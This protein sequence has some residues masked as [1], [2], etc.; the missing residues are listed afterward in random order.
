MGWHTNQL[1]LICSNHGKT[2]KN[3][4]WDFSISGP[5]STGTVRSA[6][7]PPQSRERLLNNQ[8]SPGRLLESGNQGLPASRN[9]SEDS[10]G[11]DARDWETSYEDVSLSD[12]LSYCTI[13]SM[14][15]FSTEICENNQ[16][17]L[18]MW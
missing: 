13:A 12:P 9:T 16:F 14:C 4:G 18:K 10:F 1:V 7:K 5:Q 3:A 6:V 17:Y 11:K 8:A 2:P 15:K